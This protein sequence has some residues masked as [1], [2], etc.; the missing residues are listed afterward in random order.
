NPAVSLSSINVGDLPNT[1]SETIVYQAT[2]NNP[3]TSPSDA[4]TFSTQGTYT[5]GFTGSPKLTDDPNTAAAN[6]AT[7]VHLIP[8][9]NSSTATLAADA[10]QLIIT[11]SGFDHTT[12]GNNVVT[13][14]NGATGTVTAATYTQLTVTSLTGLVSGSLTATVSVNG[15]SNPSAVQVAT[16]TPVVTSSTASLAVNAPTLV[17]NGFGFSTTAPN[18]TGSFHLGAAGTVTTATATQLT[19]TFTTQPT[20]LG[21]LTAS[22]TSNSV[23]STNLSPAVQVATIVPAPTVTANNADRAQNV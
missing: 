16:V 21:S 20:S 19:V 10:T 1:R 12:P 5:G 7:V 6:D 17:I 9:V 22:V 13:F 4:T 3:L 15:T 14:N 18:T 23:S 11:G 2:V 8:T